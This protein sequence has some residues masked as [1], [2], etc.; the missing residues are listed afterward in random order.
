[1]LKV[2]PERTA[3]YPSMVTDVILISLVVGVRV[4]E[5]CEGMA[6]QVYISLTSFWVN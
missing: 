5:P 1:M 3:S 6:S 2:L 4:T